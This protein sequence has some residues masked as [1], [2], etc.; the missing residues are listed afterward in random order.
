[1]NT[2]LTSGGLKVH[3]LP[4]CLS[5]RGRHLQNICIKTLARP[6]K[7][8]EDSMLPRGPR[9]PPLN[10]PSGH[11]RLTSISTAGTPKTFSSSVGAPPSASY[12]RP[13]KHRGPQEPS[14]GYQRR[15][16]NGSHLKD[17][18]QRW[19]KGHTKKYDA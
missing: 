12:R 1:M 6:T 16:I 11:S 2:S 14:K 15:N 9:Q 19:R 3:H 7:V 17:A 18:Q 13:P 10:T 8:G 5:H 4:R